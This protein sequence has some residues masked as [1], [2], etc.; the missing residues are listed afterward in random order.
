MTECLSQGAHLRQTACGLFDVEPGLTTSTPWEQPGRKLVRADGL[1]RK[2][3][4]AA[5]ILVSMPRRRGELKHL[6]KLA[7][8]TTEGAFQSLWSGEPN[9]SRRPAE[10]GR[11]RHLPEPRPSH[12]YV[13]ASKTTVQAP[14]RGLSRVRTPCLMKEATTDS[15]CAH[16]SSRTR[17]SC[18]RTLPRRWKRH[19]VES[20]PARGSRSVGE[21]GLQGLPSRPAAPSQTSNSPAMPNG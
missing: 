10:N 2:Y 6:S 11:P 13:D 14:A 12:S 20:E 15:K 16:A 18:S 17:P 9:L 8:R 3:G 4:L 21:E 19:P 1:S 5:R 7:A